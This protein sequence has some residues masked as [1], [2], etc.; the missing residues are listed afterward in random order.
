MIVPKLLVC[1][2]LLASFA[3][4]DDDSEDCI[5]IPGCLCFGEDQTCITQDAEQ[6]DLIA[7]Y[8]FDQIYALDQVGNLEDWDPTPDSGPSWGGHGNSAYLSENG[9]S[10]LAHDDLLLQTEITYAFWLFV[11]D[12][13]QMGW[14][15]IMHK[16]DNV[17]ENSPTIFLYPDDN[18][19]HLRFATED[20]FATSVDSNGELL[21]GA[22]T[23]VAVVFSTTS[24]SIYINGQLDTQSTTDTSIIFN[25]GPIYFGGDPW[26]NGIECFVDD[27]RI[28]STM[29]TSNPFYPN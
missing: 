28:Y 4:A 29:L 20:N 27:F 14:K 26:Q 18:R 19:L 3:F 23:H 25:D 16:G 8:T 22:W 7:W 21:E 12:A 15:V 17:N 5:L 6:E 13:D 24:V 1:A 9:Y 10:M 2:L 11:V